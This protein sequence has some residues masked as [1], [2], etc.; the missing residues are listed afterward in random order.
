MCLVSTIDRYD[1][2][3]TMRWRQQ[4]ASYF[5]LIISPIFRAICEGRKEAGCDISSD[6]DE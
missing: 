4:R 5:Q 6:T 3:K 2:V 1:V